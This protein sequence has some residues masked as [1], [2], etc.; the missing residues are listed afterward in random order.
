MKMDFKSGLRKGLTATM[1]VVMTTALIPAPSL[2]ATQ[3]GDASAALAVASS[4]SSVAASVAL[5]QTWSFDKSSGSADDLQNIQLATGTY[6]GIAID[7]SA[8]GAKFSPRASDTQVN[9]GTKLSFDVASSEAGATLSLQLSGGT[10]SLAASGNS[11]GVVESVSSDNT[12]IEVGK[13]G[14]TVTLA[15]TGTTYLKSASLTY[16]EAPVE[17]PGTPSDATTDDQTY[18]LTT[19]D[20]SSNTIQATTGSVSPSG[21]TS[22]LKVDATNGKFAPRSTDTQVNAGT[23][24]YVPIAQDAQGAKITVNG[25]N[26]N[27]LVLNVD[28]QSATSNQSVRVNT[29]S[30]RYVPVSFTLPEGAQS[31]SFYVTSIQV[32]YA[33]NENQFPGDLVDA[34]ATDKTWDLSSDTTATRPTYESKQGDFD[35]LKID[36]SSG[37]FAPRAADTQVNA[38][39]TI[40][41]PAAQDEKGAVLRIE[42]SYMG[43]VSMKVDGQDAQ[44][45]TD[46]AIDTSKMRYIPVSFSG[47]GNCYL[48]GISVD[49]K[50]DATE[51]EHVVTV[52]K[53]SNYQYQTINDALSAE[54]SSLKDHLVLSIAPGDYNERVVVTKPGVILKNADRSGNQSVTIHASY[55][56]S[57]NMDDNGKFAPLDDHDLGTDQ[58]A[59]VLVDSSAQGFS[60]HGI[61]FQNDYNVVDNT[62]A[63]QMTP[64]VAFNSKADKV[65]LS[66]CKFNGRQDT[67][68]VE[69]QGNRVSFDSCDITGTVDFIFG[70]AD[71]YFR[72]CNL[73][74]VSFPGKDNGYFTAANTKSGYTGLV[75]SHCTLT[76]DEGIKQASLG[77]PWQNLCAADI[78]VTSKGTTY[79]NID[80]SKPNSSY[81]NVSSAVT[82][83]GCTMPATA[84]LV[85][86]R[87]SLWRGKDIT[88]KS[89]SVTYE[90]TV[91]FSEI[92]CVNPDS[93]AVVD[94]GNLVLGK[95]LS[96]S[97]DTAEQT[98]LNEMKIGE[99]Y[100]Q[101]YDFSNEVVSRKSVY[102]LYNQWSGEHLF[103]TSYDEYQLLVKLGWNG[104]D[105]AWDSP[106][107]G[108]PVYRLYNPYSGDHHYTMNK[109]EYQSLQTL[110][111]NG[112]GVSFY[113]CSKDDVARGATPVYRLF[114]PWLTVGTHL[115]TISESEYNNLSAIGWQQ[116]GVAFYA[117]KH[118]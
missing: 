49:Y 11:D 38:G 46:I 48:T 99:K 45:G 107:A 35:G 64:A 81:P 111:W 87:W 94:S 109:E 50:S 108:E 61:T 20:A 17:F 44:S 13:Q 70:D 41:V 105:V 65:T 84:K 60:A 24:I 82:Y 77:R 110:G 14:G 27:N 91:R 16:K 25:N 12:T 68:Y 54:S 89:V 63:G 92:S 43:S 19:L 66:D 15:F 98:A 6:Q 103:T 29:S 97:G 78:S 85:Q 112:E 96:D 74:M 93:T 18:D 106:D 88:G 118:E 59:T 10:A 100:W 47:N 72:N 101:P 86:G 83:I 73:K 71:A 67:V 55:Y 32:A 42:S 40:Y 80:T 4:S 36:A 62:S 1:S 56:S 69:G 52:G 58:C 115:F 114:N 5:N 95:V 7:A 116:E 90:P 79:S 2:A 34:T 57:N 23:I 113:S 39:T 28:G 3:H 117:Y 104:E 30:T 8:N 22:A 53:G 76:A 37:K 26:Y 33:K 31:G 75:F 51:T 9:P 21:S 102:R